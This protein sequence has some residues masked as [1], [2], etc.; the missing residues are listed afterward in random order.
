MKIVFL[1]IDGVLNHELF[2]RGY[3]KYPRKTIKRPLDQIDQGSVEILNE[4]VKATEA[5]IVISSTW[6]IN[7]SPKEMQGFLEHFGFIGEV[8]GSTPRCP[9]KYSVR[10]NEIMA[11]IKENEKLI[12]QDSAYYDQYVIFDDDSDMLYWQRNNFIHVDR[13]CGITPSNVYQAVKILN[14]NGD[15]LD[16]GI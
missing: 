6:R 10:G 3:S 16:L 4:L 2:Y 12:G 8:I 1:D 13:Y 5:K 14:R 11:W 9:E 15:K 7:Y